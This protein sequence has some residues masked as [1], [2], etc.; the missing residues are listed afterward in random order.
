MSWVVSQILMRMMQEQDLIMYHSAEVPQAGL[1]SMRPTEEVSSSTESIGMPATTELPV[2]TALFPFTGS[3]KE[4]VNR[5]A[6]VMRI[7]E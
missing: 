1:T 3:E 2:R 6:E 5:N 7:M 4:M